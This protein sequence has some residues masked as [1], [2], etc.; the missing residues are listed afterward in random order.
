MS[1]FLGNVTDLINAAFVGGTGEGAAA[2]WIPTVV[3]C[4][5]G[6]PL[7][8]VGF[9]LSIAGFSIGCIKRLTRLG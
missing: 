1:A 9:V 8:L 6:N 7:L 3:S 4:I 2:G 5:T